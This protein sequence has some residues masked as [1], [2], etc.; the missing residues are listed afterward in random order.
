M[1]PELE[2]YI[3]RYYDSWLGCSR[4][5]CSLNGIYQEAYDLLADVLEW[6]C[7]R[8]ETQLLDMLAHEEAGDRKLFFFVRKTLHYKILYYRLNRC[9]I[10]CTPDLLA[11]VPCSDVQTE[12]PEELFDAF[13]VEEAKFRSDDFF[14][15][16]QQYNGTG[17][18]TRYVTHVKTSYGVRASAR[19]IAATETG[20][21]RQFER[22]KSAIAFLQNPPPPE[23]SGDNHK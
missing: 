17:R 3:R 16:G 13:R 15:L 14:D 4:R 12:I 22:R 1:C 5:W 11:D 9:R 2:T 7:R 8:S 23:K 19:Y 6:L 10:S 21:R 20:R 18:L